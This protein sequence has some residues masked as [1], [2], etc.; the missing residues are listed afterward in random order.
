MTAEYRLQGKVSVDGGAASAQLKSLAT[1]VVNAKNKVKETGAAAREAAA[2]LRALELAGQGA[3]TEAAQLR[4]TYQRLAAAEVILGQEAAQ[5]AAQMRGLASASASAAPSLGQIRSSTAN[6]GQQFGDIAQGVAAG[7]SPVQIFGQQAGQV[8]FAVSGLGGT[9]GSVGAFLSG[10]WG[11]ILLGATVVAASLGSALLES[12]NAAEEAAKKKEDQR[13]VTERL[14][15]AMKTLDAATGFSNRSA[16]EASEVAEA[17]AAALREE[18]AAANAA[19]RAL[20]NRARAALQDERQA[21]VGTRN[22]NFGLNTVN[23][24]R[25]AELDRQ[26]AGLDAIDKRIAAEARASASSAAYGRATRAA[27]AATSAAAAA[28]QRLAQT[29]RE[30]RDALDAGRISEAQA[31]AQIGTAIRARDAQARSTKDVERATKATSQ[32]VQALAKENRALIDQFAPATAAALKYAD[33][34]AEIEKAKAR[35]L[36]SADEADA[37]RRGAFSDRIGSSVADTARGRAALRGRL[38]SSG[39]DIIDGRDVEGLS[40]EKGSLFKFDLENELKR[41]GL[42]TGEKVGEGFSRRAL[43]EAVAIG[44]LIGGQLGGIVSTIGGLIQGAQTGNFTGVGGRIG[45]ALTLLSAGG[46]GL[47][48]SG[49]PLKGTFGISDES[50]FGAGFREV[51]TKPL[52]SLTTKLGSAFGRNS[53]FAKSIG[54]AAGG[55]ALG[56]AVGELGG[57]LGLNVSKTGSTVGG[58]VG[59]VAGS[60]FGPAGGAIGSVLGGLAGGLIGGLF[61]NKSGSTTVS[62]SGDGRIGQSGSGNASIQRATAGLGTTISDTVQGIADALGAEVGAFSVSIG[63]FRDNFR[64]DRTGTGKIRGSTVT[65]TKDEREA[66][67]L[68][69]ADAIRDGAIVTSPRVQSALN[70]YADNVNKAVAEALKVKGLEDLLAN[71]DNPFTTTFRDLELTLRDR[72]RVARDFGFDV[73]EIEKINAEDRKR[74]LEETLAQTTG[75]IKA[76][77]ADLTIGSRATGSIGERL[78][79]LSAERDRVAGLARGGDTSQLDVLAALVSQIDDLQR[80]AFG[81]TAPA[82][83]GRDESVALLNELV[84]STEARIREAAEAA[85]GDTAATNDLLREANFSLDDLVNG[86]SLTNAQLQRLIEA[87]GLTGPFGGYGL[88]F[89]FAR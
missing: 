50:G 49:D 41:A 34:L 14:A 80:E 67:S 84:A 74:L 21:S 79:G 25:A 66:L 28:D 22:S 30:I 88:N 55:A 8:A 75:S 65:G 39:Q 52:E 18:E 59:G 56:S 57:A 37:A 10:P 64:V 71:R 89:E 31:T 4:E 36:I 15:E 53:D 5:A 12:G 81:A 76:L 42:A 51:F 48:A 35:G 77:L 73:L 11:A 68:A 70:K 32:A 1:D 85:R 82:A 86:V 27:E 58:A 17:S 62:S 2:G 54:K 60:I 61:N 29:K 23:D 46:R 45:G 13:S 9:L 43:T 83:Q 63:K 3:S 26:E 19:A 40:S 16:R 72:V 47:S 33:A 20:L 78:A 24:N 38:S 69:V 6:L 7:I 87:G 44:Q